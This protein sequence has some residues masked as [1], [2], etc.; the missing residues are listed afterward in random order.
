MSS[1]LRF[2]PSRARVLAFTVVVAAAALLAGCKDELYSSLSEKEA[3]Q[4]MA[5]LMANAIATDKTQDKTGFTLSVDRN[6]MLRAIAVLKDAGYPKTTHESMGKVFQQSGI[7]SSPFEERVRYVYALG[8]QVAETLSHIDGVVT[9]RVNIVLPKTPELGQ[10]VKPSS[11]AVFIKYEPGVDLDYFIPQI[12]RLVSSS[13]EGLNYSDVTVV[14]TQETPMKTMTSPIGP[15]TVEVAPG[16]SVRSGDQARFW[17]FIFGGVGL[18][19][20]LIGLNVATLI[21]WRGFGLFKGSKA[22]TA[23]PAIEPS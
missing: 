22:N 6:D 12:K 1:Q 23:A 17:E 5:I 18:L 9:A 15:R 13:I 20:L 11:A 19:A 14:L 10:P 16:L 3:N 2:W 7:M 8:Q 4:M 21:A